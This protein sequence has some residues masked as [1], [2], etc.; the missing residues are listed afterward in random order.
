M[1]PRHS[2]WKVTALAGIGYLLVTLAVTY[3]GWL[4]PLD[5]IPGDMG[6]PVLNSW[7]IAWDVHA[8]VEDPARL[9]DA[10]IFY[11][12]RN[13]L[14]Y[15]EH[16]LGSALLTA[17]VLIA[18]GEPLLAYNLAFISSF[19]LSGLG[20]YLLVVY[21]TGNRWAGFVSGLIFGFTP[22][23]FA[24]IIHLHLLTWQWLPFAI[25]YLSRYFRHS[26]FR[27]LALFLFFFMLQ[28]ATSWHIGA[29]MAFVVLLLV[30]YRLVVQRDLP[31]RR[32]VAL[33]LGVLLVALLL[34][35]L[36]RPYLAADELQQQR[37]LST[38]EVF[39]LRWTDF[40]AAAPDNRHFGAATA[41]L[42][43]DPMFN[44][45]RLLFLGFVMP[46]LAAATWYFWMKRRDREWR[47]QIAAFWLLAALALPLTFGP[48][49]QIGNWRIPMPYALLH[50]L[51]PQMTL[52]RVPARWV[53]VIIFALAVLAGFALSALLQ[54]GWFSRKQ[55]F[56]AGLVAVIALL[57]LAESW[58][59]PLSMAEPGRLSKLSPVYSWIDEQPDDFA[60]V[61]LPLHA[62][63]GPQSAETA[64]MYASTS[65]WRPLVNGYS[66]ISPEDNAALWRV[67]S[68]FPDAASLQAIQ[69]L[70]KQ[71]V[72][73]L[74]LHAA[75]AP[76][77]ND[78][79]VREGFWRAGRSIDLHLRYAD[80][81]RSEFVYEINPYG[82][83]LFSG[84]ASLADSRW[85]RL[86]QQR[87]GAVF[88]Q[89][90]AL[91]GFDVAEE[92][93][94]LAL[95]LY[96]QALHAPT[97]NY[98]AFVHLLDGDGNRVAQADGI[99]DQGRY[100]TNRWQI[101]EVVRDVYRIPLAEAGNGRQFFVGLYNEETM[102][103]LEVGANPQARDNG[104]IVPR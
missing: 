62:W 100:P 76:F 64:R 75:E 91:L 72:R 83:E 61:E 95:T 35:P 30:V 10:N 93:D 17:P 44:M 2:K 77:D 54:T 15:S 73:Y 47:Q 103:R 53:I 27:D 80:P 13:T 81:A 20:M 33:C 52:L 7:I 85:A 74:V 84:E 28:I 6:D 5:A 70:G 31:R 12:S 24:G 3:P 40:L 41:S 16:L 42:R 68:G 56:S 18:S 87:V 94:E 37:P 58:T 14:A 92:E 98:K 1:Q 102:E 67:L 63:P 45:E 23:R 78:A 99:P 34:L 43:T 104:V 65:H 86:A 97:G 51:F 89:E 38:T 101:G 36:I 57:V 59:A 26:R 21:L 88:G 71:G 60:I 4:R 8:L 79:W 22:Y 25:L 48:V 19:V 82:A 9:F 96:W 39:S 90:I 69:A 55:R 66:G 32:L 29:F 50:A 11:P 49:L 46:L